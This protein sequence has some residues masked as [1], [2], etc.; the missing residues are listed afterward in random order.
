MAIRKISL[1]AA[2]YSQLAAPAE[3]LMKTLRGIADKVAELLS[4]QNTVERQLAS[5]VLEVDIGGNKNSPKLDKLKPETVRIPELKKLRTNYAVLRDLFDTLTV[6]ES[7]EA[8]IQTGLSKSSDINPAKAIAEVTR[9]KNQVKAGIK[10]ALAFMNKLNDDHHP[11]ALAKFATIVQNALSANL[12]YETI[13]MRGFVFEAD[14]T[15]C[16]S[17]YIRLGGVT[18]DEGEYHP[19]VYVVLTYKTGAQPEVY[20]A[21]LTSFEPPSDNL[22]AKKVKSVQD[23]LTAL[24]LL[25]DLEKVS[26]SMGNLPVSTVL[27]PES[28][29]KSLFSYEQY[30]SKIVADEDKI[31]FG[32]KATVSERSLLDQISTNIFREFK[33]VV[34]KSNARLRMSIAKTGKTYS[35]HFYFVTSNDGPLVD[36][37]DVQFLA[38][39]FNLDQASLNK[40]VQVMNVGV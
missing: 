10:S 35:L 40:I 4:L 36:V 20:T 15:L 32:L 24:S 33:S 38:D 7:T 11:K 1:Q 6:L 16:F 18:D 8:K 39:R 2:V 30:I 28:V 5:M 26:N 3:D 23:T 22:L 21:V 9:L 34:R 31:T 37:E 13:G 17:D 27:K 12:Q 19:E 25:F 29:N 14:E